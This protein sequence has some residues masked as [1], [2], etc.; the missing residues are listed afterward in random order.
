MFYGGLYR[1]LFL[2]LVGG[3]LGVQTTPNEA[4]F[5]TACPLN[6]KVSG[7]P[8]L[9]ERKE[10]RVQTKTF[11]AVQLKKGESLGLNAGQEFACGT[12]FHSYD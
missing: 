9:E 10:G 1:G 3:I 8:L 11:D 5:P 2:G 12:N 7:F 4:P 6:F